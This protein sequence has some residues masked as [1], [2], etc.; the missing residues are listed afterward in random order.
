MR[1]DGLDRGV[2]VFSWDFELAWGFHDKQH[3]PERLHAFD[4]RKYIGKLIDILER[5]SVPTTWAT[6]GHLLLE[7]CS[8]TG[9]RPHANIP[10]PTD[11]WYDNDPC[12][13]VQKDPLWY[14][15]DLVNRLR[16]CDPTQ[17]IGSHTFSH[18]TTDVGKDILAAEL[19][20]CRQLAGDEEMC[21]FVSP[22]HGDVPP[23][24]LA[25]TGYTSYRV[26]STGPTWRRVVSFYTGVGAPETSV[27][28][29]DPSGVWRHPVSTYFF[30]NP[31]NEIQRRLPRFKRRW[32]EAGLQRAASNSEVFHVWAH[33]HNFI[34]DEHA[35]D[36]FRWLVSR[37]ADLRDDE[38]I[39]PMTMRELTERVE[40]SR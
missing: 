9:D 16:S 23:S 5:Y 20:E 2:F 14:A 32:F 24:V 33:P 22:R 31:M 13:N 25:D 15:S 18:V 26:P 40:R 39:K 30:Y 17:E 36:Q 6:V 21:S 1:N 29:R 38:R 27:P 10:S 7:E 12:T 3:L 34:G 8:R 19:T 35:I 4:S 11:N 28:E 37:V